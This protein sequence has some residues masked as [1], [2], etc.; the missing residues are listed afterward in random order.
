[1]RS[2]ILEILEKISGIPGVSEVSMTTNGVFLSDLAKLLKDA[3]LRR[4]NVS[5]DTLDAEI[6][7]M[8]TGVDALEKV[9]M[10]IKSTVEANN[11]E[12][13]RMIDFAERSNAILQLIEL[14][15][16]NEN[17]FYKKH[18]LDMA[19]IEK[20]LESKAEKIIIRSCQRFPDSHF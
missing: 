17:G 15:S 16:A 11:N 7:K 18:H 5:L 13:W 14:E 3:G 12:V 4:V 20:E 8:I 9:I 10:G 2:D 1:M 19:P 6:Y